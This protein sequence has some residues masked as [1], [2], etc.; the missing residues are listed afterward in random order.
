MIRRKP[1]PA[2]SETAIGFLPDADEI[3]RQPLPLSARIT[4]HTIVVALG[5]FLLWAALSE[6]DQVV[7]ARGR[8]ITQAP[9]L[10]VQPIELAIVQS[11]HVQQGQIVRKGDLLATLDPTFAS[12]DQDQ[13]LNRLTSLDTQQ[14]RLAAELDGTAAAAETG[15]NPADAAL[16]GRLAE[17]RKAVFEARVAA[18]QASIERARASLAANRNNQDMLGKRVQSLREIESMQEKLVADKLGPR[19]GLLEARDRRLEIEQELQAAIS[20][21]TEL[22]REIQSLIAEKNAFETGWRQQTFEELLTTSRERESLQ[23]QLQK[24][25][26]RRDLV[27][28]TAPADAVVL[29]VAKV[30]TGTIVREAE[31]LFTLVPIGEELVAEVQI[32]AADVGYVKTGDS[33]R[34][35]FD[36]FPFQ[37]HGSLDADV[38]TISGD[39]FRRDGS[40]PTA[41]SDA[42]YRARLKL[43]KVRLDNMAATSRLL[44][45]MVLNAEIVVGKRTVLSYLMWPLTRALQESI[46]EP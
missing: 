40:D 26:K 22:G 12:A 2:Q 45:G 9:N 33:A 27:T 44:P 10:V 14:R 19:L 31:T 21:E 5:V 43:E 41:S 29:E 20:R 16:Q 46:R 25:D 42:Y 23:E 35:K 39:A 8:L 32:D 17:E 34:L 6:V 11:I 28:L 18:L 24:V 36:A 7:V 38:L 4:L 37:R 30:N 3:E 1:D 13:L 15:N